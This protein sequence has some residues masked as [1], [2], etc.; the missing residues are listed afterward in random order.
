MSKL[1]EIEGDIEITHELFTHIIREI[2]PIRDVTA[3]LSEITTQF[4]YYHGIMIKSKRILDDTIDIL[5]KTVRNDYDQLNA[6]A[7]E[8]HGRLNNSD[9]D[10]TDALDKLQNIEGVIS[11]AEVVE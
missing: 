6:L 5:D 7:S 10:Y 3:E 8:L 2:T 9:G 1:I 11:T 4:S